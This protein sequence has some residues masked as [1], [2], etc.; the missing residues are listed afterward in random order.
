MEERDRLKVWNVP[1]VILWWVNVAI[2]CLAIFRSWSMTGNRH[3]KT[4]ADFLLFF[5]WFGQ[6]LPS[7]GRYGKP[8]KT[9]SAGGRSGRASLLIFVF[10]RPRRYAKKS[11]WNKVEM[12][13]DQQRFAVFDSFPSFPPPLFSLCF[14]LFFFFLF[15]L[16][17]EIFLNE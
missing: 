7:D 2:K 8:Q 15:L 13:L 3:F 11:V 12:N 16:I 5:F 9:G 4:L 17:F 1:S 6:S 10:A 14:F